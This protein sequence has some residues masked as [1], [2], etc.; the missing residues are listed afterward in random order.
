MPAR[1][2]RPSEDAPLPAMVYF[3]GGGWTLLD[4][5]TH[6]R[7]MRAYARR[8]G[9]AMIGLDYPLA[10]EVRFP[11][12]LGLCVEAV[13]NIR[14]AAEDLG[15]SPELIVLGGD[16][17]GANLALAAAMIGA[18][19]GCSSPLGL[20][21]NYGVFDCDLNR[22]S[23]RAFSDPPYLLSAGRMAYFWDNYCPES[24]ARADPLA[25]PLRASTAMLAPLPRVHLTIAA[26]DVLVD[27]NK[28][29]ARRLECAGVT[30][31]S[32]VYAEAAHGFLEAVD[33]SPV[34]DRAVGEGAMWLRELARQS[35]R[36]PAR[37]G[38]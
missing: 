26:Q 10:P 34:A 31:T 6:D 1:L 19:Q 12:S 36:P 24:A 22:P 9:W 5:D 35:R 3:H 11:D 16:S 18:R 25:S 14:G 4:L 29:M 2:Y 27:E 21:L 28:D 38:D 23:Y 32:L 13:A 8:S 33:H 17:S 7:L 20:M 37:H 15:L 30:V